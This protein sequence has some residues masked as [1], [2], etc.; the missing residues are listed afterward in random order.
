LPPIFKKQPGRSNK[1]K[2]RK[3]IDKVQNPYKMKKA[4]YAQKCSLCHQV[5]QKK[6]SCKYGQSTS[7]AHS[8][9]LKGMGKSKATQVWFNT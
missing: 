9:P 5:G 6:Q 1:Q 2:R 3:D 7:E 8:N 4:G